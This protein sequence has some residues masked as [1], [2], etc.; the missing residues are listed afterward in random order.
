MRIVFAASEVYPYAKT[1]GLADVVGALARALVRAGHEVLVVAPWYRTLRADPPPLWIGD[2]DVPYDGGVEPAGVGTLEADGVRF[3]FVGH[4]DFARDAL[5]GYPDDVARFA[6]FAR[7]VPAVAD[8]VGVRPDVLHVHDWQAS[9][10]LPVV[11]HGFHLPP[12]WPHVASVLT[13]HNVQHQGVGDL[14]DVVHRLRLPRSVRASGLQRFGAANALQGGIAFATRVTTV[15]PTYAEEITTPAYG[16]GLDGTLR[17][18]RAK[19]RGILNGIDVDV[20]DP[21][22]DPHLAVRYDATDPS[23]KAANAAALRR[24][25][26]LEAGGPLLASVSRFA[27]QKGIDLLLE[28]IP[29]LRAQGWRVALLGAGDAS[30][31]AAARAAAD[32]DPGGV[33]VHVGVDEGLAHRVYAGADAFAIPSRFEPCGL[34][35]MI[36]MRYGTLPIARATG[37]LRDTIRDG[38]TGRLF[39]AATAE[40]LVAAAGDVRARLEDGAADAMRVAAMR[41][42]FDWGASADAYV[43]VYRE[44]YDASEREST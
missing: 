29:A 26:G 39:E 8:R 9:L 33:A 4:P 36:A 41:E 7:A 6:R 25:V 18:E 15:S 35:Q 44:A 2:V 37:G 1:G 20:W 14:D 5:Y 27:E 28:A 24:E 38:V 23:R 10:L 30:L 16:F 3:A 12:G 19:L 43:D 32:A 22:T 21:S 17:H 34:T 13:I 40:A 42:R 11:A 31:E